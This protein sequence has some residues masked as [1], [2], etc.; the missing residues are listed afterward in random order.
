MTWSMVENIISDTYSGCLTCQRHMND[1][2]AKSSVTNIMFMVSNLLCKW[3]GQFLITWV[4]VD[5]RRFFCPNKN[6]DLLQS[7]DDTVL[8]TQDNCETWRWKDIWFTWKKNDKKMVGIIILP[9]HLWIST[10]MPLIKN[11]EIQILLSLAKLKINT[12]PLLLFFMF[13]AD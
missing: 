10:V 3:S 12:I 4:G 6:K 13:E 9:S 8:H 5:H 11:R 1:K 7:G 2:M